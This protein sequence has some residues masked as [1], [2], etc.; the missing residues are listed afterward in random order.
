MINRYDVFI[1]IGNEPKS[2]MQI[3]K[4]IIEY[5]G[6]NVEPREFSGLMHRYLCEIFNE[7]DNIKRGRVELSQDYL[8]E[9]DKENVPYYDI[10]RMLRM[11]YWK[12]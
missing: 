9:L 3:A 11:H 12:D 7:Y 1:Q 6:L 8:T 2:T 10:R 4:D 5:K